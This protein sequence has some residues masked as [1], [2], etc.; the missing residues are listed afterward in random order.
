M[1]GLKER[2]EQLM[3]ELARV[4]GEAKDEPAAR[5]TESECVAERFSANLKLLNGLGRPI[6]ASGRL[7]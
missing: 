4:R 6:G 5:Q 3:L 7:C 2:N 1:T